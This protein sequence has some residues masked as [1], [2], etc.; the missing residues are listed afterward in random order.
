[1]LPTACSGK[2]KLMKSEK[3]SAALS[4]IIITCGIIAVYLNSLNGVWVFDDEAY[5]LKSTA[6]RNLWPPSYMSGN[7][8]PLLFLSLALNYAISGYDILSY[9]IAD[10]F[11]HICNSLLLFGIIRSTLTLPALQKKIQSGSTRISLAASLI[12]GLHPL[13]TMCVSYTWQRGEQMM[14]F[15]YMLTLFLFIKGCSTEK[16]KW[17]ICS[18]ITCLAGMASKEVMVSAPIMLLLYDRAFISGSFLKGLSRRKVFYA[19]CALSWLLLFAMV[20]NTAQDFHSNKAL[21]FRSVKCT[22]LQYLLTMPGVYLHYFRLI[23]VPH[24]LIFDYDW[25]IAESITA[26]LPAVIVMSAVVILSIIALIKN[27]ASGVAAS[28]F[29]ML[30]MPTS[31]VMPMPDALIEYRLYLP[32]AVVSA[33]LVP[34]LAI[35][36]SKIFDMIK[37][38]NNRNFVKSRV[39]TGMPLLIIVVFGLLTV[40]RNFV[41][42]SELGLWADT[43]SKRPQS[44]RAQINY[45]RLLTEDLQPEKALIH[46]KKALELC[47]TD[48]EIHLNLGNT[49]FL[50]ER[51]K[52]AELFFRNSLKLRPESAKAHNNLGNTLSFMNKFSEALEHFKKAAELSNTPENVYVNI[53]CAYARR[54]NLTEAVKYFRKSIKINPKYADAW[55]NLGIAQKESNNKDKAAECMKKALELNPGFENARK[56][57]ENLLS[58]SPQKP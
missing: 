20:A 43:V 24:P 45:G 52:D 6:I 51:Y 12:W 57:L 19:A 31:S 28:V 34:A 21:G 13:T 2:I 8:R 5:I 11:I 46:L 1:M 23:A 49:L 44:Y 38:E 17:F 29:F 26:E 41:Y 39:G 56:E 16:R 40:N 4:L 36:F 35:L 47:S 55:F 25:K 30:M 33:A 32:L 50:M 18:A 42:H 3:P 22:P 14:A 15:F 7:S 27:K 10:I 9:H 48:P 53:G 54:K 58:G 37:D